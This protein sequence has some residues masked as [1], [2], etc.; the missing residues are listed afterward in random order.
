MYSSK[1]AVSP[2]ARGWPRVALQHGGGGD[3]F[4]PAR[5][6]APPRWRA[7]AHTE[8]VS[9]PARGW[10]PVRPRRGAWQ[11]GFPACAGMA[12]PS[13]FPRSP[14]TGFPRRRGNGLL[15]RTESGATE[16]VSRLRGD[17]PISP[18]ARDT[19]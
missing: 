16:W 15:H 12:P 19:A 8:R 3:G 11:G 1:K 6:I 9:P 18:A 2:P 4:P 7:V 10:P 14:K 13:S 5:G 17:G